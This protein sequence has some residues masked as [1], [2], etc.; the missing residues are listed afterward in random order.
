MS[1]SRSPGGGSSTS[2]GAIA[3]AG[4]S[5]GSSGRARWSSASTGTWHPPAPVSPH[6]DS[7]REWGSH[8]F[9]FNSRK[10][11]KPEWGGQTLL[12]DDGGRFDYNSAPEFED[13][14]RSHTI[15]CVGNVSALLARCDR[16]WHGVREI[17][18]PEGEFRK[19]FIVVVNPDSLLWRARDRLIGK[20]KQRF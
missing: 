19:V 14:E 5:R 11:W 12:L 18:C 20:T 7:R 10:T 4:S 13:F 8:L 9:Y 3:I 16:G 2:S 15:E 1:R 6:C 17:E